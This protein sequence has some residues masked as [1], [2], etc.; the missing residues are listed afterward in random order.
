MGILKKWVVVFLTFCTLHA[1]SSIHTIE[2]AIH[3]MAIYQASVRKNISLFNEKLNSIAIRLRLDNREE[4]FK[5]M[6][7]INSIVKQNASLFQVLQDYYNNTLLF[8]Y[9]GGILQGYIAIAQDVQKST[10][11][12]PLIPLVQEI[13]GQLQ[14]MA[15]LEAQITQLIEE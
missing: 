11:L 2:E 3:Q 15:M 1:L 14:V 4:H 5:E 8:D 13:I 9:L 7:V 12:A 10:Q 6:G